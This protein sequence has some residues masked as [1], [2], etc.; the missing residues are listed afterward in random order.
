MISVV[1][2]T[3]NNFSELQETLNSIQ[4][5]QE[6]ESVVINGGSCEESKELLSHYSGTV[7]NELDEGISDAFNKGFRS[8]RGQA[9]AYLNSGDILL[10]PEYYVWAN[11]V[12]L[13]DPS[14]AFT[15]SDL[16]FVDSIAGVITMKPRGQK[17]INLGEGMPFPHPT[18]VVRREI[19]EQIGGFSKDFKI[20]MDFD[21]V[22]K[23][24][25][26][27]Y[28][29]VYYPHATVKM[30][31]SGISTARELQGIMEC[32]TSLE[33]H[34]QFSGVNR[35]GF[36][37]RLLIYRIRNGI[38]SVLGKNALRFVKNIKTKLK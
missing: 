35:K 13:E 19:F 38:K 33:A 37:K 1:T 6:I 34:G 25:S 11:R 24:L 16:L 15:Y 17:E 18:M 27:G 4:G 20:A 7:V 36:K 26:A 22:V 9:V 31:G 30:D 5:V 14:V 28:R 3:Y 2:I 12:F 8:S 10:D 23:L 29:G 32:K 21:F